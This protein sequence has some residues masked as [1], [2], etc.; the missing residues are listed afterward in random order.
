MDRVSVFIAKESHT[1]EG[2]AFRPNAP[3]QS[4]QLINHRERTAFVIL[5]LARFET[6]LARVEVNIR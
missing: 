5:R 1:G 3:E 2:P 4:A 6:D